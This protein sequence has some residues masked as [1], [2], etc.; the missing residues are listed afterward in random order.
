MNK[1]TA[2]NGQILLKVMLAWTETVESVRETMRNVGYI[3]PIS[4]RNRLT[5]GK[6][7]PKQT[8]QGI[9]Q[10]HACF[11]SVFLCQINGHSVMKQMISSQVCLSICK[12]WRSHVHFAC[13]TASS[14]QLCGWQCC[15]HVLSSSCPLRYYCAK[16]GYCCV[17]ASPSKTMIEYNPIHVNLR[18]DF[19]VG[20]AGMHATVTLL[21]NYYYYNI[22]FIDFLPH[23]C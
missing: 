15:V 7:N 14:P 19:V 5:T 16:D 18:F 10:R 4:R 6:K 1:Q 12:P 22:F 11:H 2:D 21:W 9:C 3:W 17:Q 23:Y 8:V 20:N 13:S